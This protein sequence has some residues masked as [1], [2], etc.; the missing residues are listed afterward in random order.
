MIPKLVEELGGVGPTLGLQNVELTH[1]GNDNL[2]PL[3]TFGIGGPAALG[4]SSKV[5]TLLPAPQKCPGVYS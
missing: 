1:K 4:Y 3:C 2:C 5:L